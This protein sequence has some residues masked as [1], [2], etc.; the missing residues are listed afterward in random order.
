MTNIVKHND[1]QKYV[2][3]SYEKAFDG[4]CERSFG[5]DFARNVI[6]FG[7]DNSSSSHTENL[8]NYFLILFEGDTFGINGSFGAP[9]KKIDINFSQAKT[10]LEFAL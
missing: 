3:S 10:K 6:M 4:K 2:Y 5:N 7:V 1:Q 8:K 9:E